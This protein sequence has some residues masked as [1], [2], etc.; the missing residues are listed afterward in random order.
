MVNIANAS[1]DMKDRALMED[2]L[3]G[4]AGLLQQAPLRRGE[5]AR[6]FDADRDDDVAPAAP[7]VAE[8]LAGQPELLPGLGPRG[9]GHLGRALRERD[10]D[11][12]SEQGRED[13]DRHVAPEVEGFR[14]L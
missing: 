2:L 4:Q 7:P 10:V 9:N 11:R 6:D 5:A 1:P 14:R 12:P 3:T 8:P 13:A